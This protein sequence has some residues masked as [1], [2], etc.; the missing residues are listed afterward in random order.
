MLH[1]FSRA[2]LR[3]QVRSLAESSRFQHAR[4]DSKN[5]GTLAQT[6][7]TRFSPQSLLLPESSL[8]RNVMKNQ[9]P[10]NQ[11]DQI[12][13]YSPRRIRRDPFSGSQQD[14]YQQ[15]DYV[16]EEPKVTYS[17][18][19]FST[20]QSSGGGILQYSD[21]ISEL[22]SQPC[23]VME[24]K[25]EFM[26]MFLGFEQANRYAILDINGNH[27]GYME[28]EDF[29]ITKAILRQVY[30]LHRPFSVRVLDRQGQHVLTVSFGIII[31]IIV[32]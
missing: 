26:N 29:G 6:Y 27:L 16:Y 30:R 24:R 11:L 7:R 20:P 17:Y 28:E 12:R 32:C 8:G 5:I 25:I 13:F 14:E 10:K 31:I 15:Q 21:P 19:Q 23:L 22:L 4:F 9:I 1:T 18:P 3:Q 2:Q